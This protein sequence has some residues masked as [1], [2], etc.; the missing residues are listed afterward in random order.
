[1]IKNFRRLA[2]RHRHRVGDGQTGGQAR[3]FDAEQVDQ[4]IHPMGVRPLDQ[5]VGL[6]LSRLVLRAVRAPS[7]EED[8]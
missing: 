8:T 1:M 3:R 2:Q 7:L 6:R 4:T 5:E